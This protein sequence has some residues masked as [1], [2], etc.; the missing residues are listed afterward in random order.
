[1]LEDL[2]RGRPFGHEGEFEV[3]DNLVDNF[4]IFYERD[5]LYLTSTRG[6]QQRINFIHLTNHLRRAL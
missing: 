2:R 4:M 5:D 1:V 6:T 3:S